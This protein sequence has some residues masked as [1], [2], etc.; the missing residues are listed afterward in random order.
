[1]SYTHKQAEIAVD[2]LDRD[3]Y[4]T[5]RAVTVQINYTI[6]I[7]NNYG[8]DADGRRGMRLVEIEDVEASVEPEVA[9][10]LLADEL[11]Q[12]TAHALKVFEQNK[13]DI[14]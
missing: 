6:Y 9:K 10:T 13:W 8:A 7:D 11:A 2:V 5:G 12:V 4:A 14:Y 1:M 3:G